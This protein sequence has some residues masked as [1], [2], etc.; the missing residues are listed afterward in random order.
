[1]KTLHCF[2]VVLAASL[3]KPRIIS[4]NGAYILDQTEYSA[5]QEKRNICQY[6]CYSV[7]VV[8]TS[9]SKRKRIIHD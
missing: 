5:K 2:L 6:N 4:I 7:F 9:V 1:M 3:N 8:V